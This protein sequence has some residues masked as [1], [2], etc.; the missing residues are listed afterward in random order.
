MF[1]PQNISLENGDVV[2]TTYDEEVCVVLKNNSSNSSKPE[3][4]DSAVIV[5]NDG[6][7]WRFSNKSTTNSS[8]S[9]KLEWWAAIGQVNDGTIWRFSKSEEYA[10]YAEFSLTSPDLDTCKFLYG[11]LK[12]TTRKNHCISKNFYQ[13]NALAT[14]LKFEKGK[15]VKVFSG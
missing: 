11:W 8:N 2:I 15:L 7:L 1:N 14:H 3:W 10:E 6:T 9:S 4:R 12:E 13:Y 5:N